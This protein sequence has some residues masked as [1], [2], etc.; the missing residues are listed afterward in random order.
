MAERLWIVAAV[1]VVALIA[2]AVL[3]PPLTRGKA[4][5][6]VAVVGLILLAVWGVAA[7]I[8]RANDPSTW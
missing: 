7:F 5:G 8:E 6:I 4:I 1:F 3:N 2:G